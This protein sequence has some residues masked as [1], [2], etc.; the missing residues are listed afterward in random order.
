MK[1]I[2]FAY[3]FAALLVFPARGVLIEP[4]E[5]YDLL[6]RGARVVDGSGNP[7]FRADVGIKNGKIARVGQIPDS[8]RAAQVIDAGGKILAPG[9]IDV[10]THVESIYDLPEAENFVR[11]G[12][13]SLVTGNCGA[14]ATN[15]A[16]YL[17]RIETQPLAVNLATLVGHNSVR[18]KVM[19]LEN[20]APTAEEL[21]QMETIV[22][23]A[24]KDGAVGFS[25]GLIYVPGNYAAT[26]EVVALARVAA[27]YHGL[28]AT[29]MRSEGAGVFDAI[30]ES[31]QI[32][33]QA[34][35]PVEISHFKIS[36]KPLW[37]HSDETLGLVRQARERGLSVTVDQYAYTAS[38]T[39]LDV[40]L[41]DWALSGGRDEGRKRLNDPATRERII[42]EMKKSLQKGER[43]DYSYAVVAGYKPNPAFD[44]LSIA[45]ITKQTR[46]S[47]KV[48][49]QIEQI[50]EMYAAGGTG[51]VYHT[52]SEDDVKRIMRA[53]FTMIASDSGVRRF[54]EGM[55]HP[56]GYGN[57]VRVLGRYVREMKNLSLEDAVRKMTSL[58][59]QTFG[60]RDRGLVR[61]GMAADL[62]IFDEKTIAETST[63]EKPHQYPI[64]LSYT[65]VN[66]QVV[67]A[68]NKLTDRRPGQALRGAGAEN[69]SSPAKEQRSSF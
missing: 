53:P 40:L 37:N 20:R 29:H 4:Q 41:P 10:H 36:S 38:S 27:K 64:G 34:N 16:E 22:E 63:F 66:G 7:W 65:I 8:A 5:D 33:E 57:N 31:L 52:M 39:S 58:P 62:V 59:A 69:K 25:T 9:F 49:Q 17:G 3:L 24:M 44:G 46:K 61:E 23:Q 11:M 68:D 21:K 12:V 30:R 15:I 2:I 47:D 18:G 19:G 26:D 50:L 48:E 55:P 42:S 54:N 43:K 45:A 51:M 28:Y 32:G 67:I 60:L 14:S 1:R 6:I 56:R 13:T 35:L